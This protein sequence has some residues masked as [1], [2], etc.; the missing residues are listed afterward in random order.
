MIG[1]IISQFCRLAFTTMN[2]ANVEKYKVRYL[3]PFWPK[4][5]AI[6]EMAQQHN[7]ENN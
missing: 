7:H 2:Y 6:G 5:S 1:I 4:K 3:S